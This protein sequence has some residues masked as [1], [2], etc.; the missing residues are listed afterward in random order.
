MGNL[1]QWQKDNSSFVKL[2]DGES[3]VG[4]YMGYSFMMGQ[5]GKEK[6]CFKFKDMNGG[7]K[8]L[9]SQSGDLINAFDEDN[10]TFKKGDKV[11]LTRFGLEKN[12]KYKV[13]APDIDFASKEYSGDPIL[14]EDGDPV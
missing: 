13:S 9:Q 4:F 7:L 12:T 6:P 1:K 3:F 2:G 14:G 5:D 10:G 8:S 11:R